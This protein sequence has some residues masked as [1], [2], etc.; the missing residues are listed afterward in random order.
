M[1][2]VKI[3]DD[4]RNELRQRLEEIAGCSRQDIGSHPNRVE[5]LNATLPHTIKFIDEGGGDRSDCM[6]YVLEIPPDLVNI[7]ATFPSILDE[8][9]GEAL[10]P[11]L[12]QAQDSEANQRIIIYFK[13]D[14]AKHIGRVTGNRVISKWGKNPVY[15][16][17]VFEVPKSYGDEYELFKRPSVPYIT[18][19]VIEFIRCHPRYIDI[20]D[21]FEDAVIECGYER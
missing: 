5:V 9:F 15:G 21:A 14:K 13:D 19:K 7:V 6:M 16:H 18:K 20:R 11:L 3:P 1:S 2:R 10:T 12:E 17:G 4:N 8:F